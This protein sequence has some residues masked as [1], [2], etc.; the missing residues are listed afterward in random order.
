MKLL[1]VFLCILAA[2][3]IVDKEISYTA[4]TPAGRTVR[5]FLG[6]NQADSIDFIRW[7]LKIVDGKEFALSCSYGISKPN[8]NGFIDE[9][10]LVLKG[11]ANSKDGTLTLNKAG[12]LLSMQVLNDNIMHLL[13]Q[14]GSLMI[15]NGGWSYTLNNFT[16]ATDAAINFKSP[17]STFKDS[18]ALEG[19]SPC[20][21]PGIIPEGVQCYKLKWYVVLYTGDANNKSGMYKIL[22]TPW[23]KQGGKTGKWTVITAKDGHIIFR[24]DKDDG[25][26][27]LN[28]LQLDNN[29]FVFTDASDKLLVGN[30]DFSYTLNRFF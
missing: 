29:I 16:P 5:D 10:K 14:D 4:S 26:A 23:R 27:L 1:V 17:R 7:Q 8:T 3:N 12:K 22:G 21:V 9:K 18:M 6:I 15:G 20:G 24:L 25:S 11:N 28:L 19:R 13:N 2:G 30:E